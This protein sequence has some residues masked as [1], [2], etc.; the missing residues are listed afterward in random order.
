[1]TTV[2][3]R[4]GQAGIPFRVQFVDAHTDA[5]IDV[6]TATVR[7]IRLRGP[8]GPTLVRTAV[9]GALPSEIEYVTQAGD[10]SQAGD[11]RIQG[12]VSGPGFAWPSDIGHFAVEHNL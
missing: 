2:T 8:V 10:L 9:A 1:V 3:H 12:F 7:E 11:W 5:P 6:S 4:V